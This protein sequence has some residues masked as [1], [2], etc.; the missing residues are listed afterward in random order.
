MKNFSKVLILMVAVALFACGNKETGK[1]EAAPA[2]V[3]KA[4]G[5]V[6]YA[7][8]DD[9]SLISKY[10]FAKDLRDV[11]LQRA[12]KLEA[13]Q[14]QRA[15]E[16]QKLGSEIE[17][18]YKNNGY[19]TEESFNADQQKLQKMQVDAQNYLGKLQQTLEQEQMEDQK[20]LQDSIENFMKEF[21]KAK[22]YEVILHK[23]A[24]WYFDEANDVTDEV[25]E[26]LNKRYTKVEKK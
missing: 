20:Q 2:G 17:R 16:I 8:V 4:Q 15:V 21:A 18:K 22:G 9:D 1:Q 6:K 5:A 14:N 7:Y 3:E 23:G 12:S 10:N 25:V 24:A 13:A 26:S 11:T 19:L